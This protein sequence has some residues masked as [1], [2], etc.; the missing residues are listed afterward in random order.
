MANFDQAHHFV[1]RAEGGY[2]ADPRDRGNWTGGRI[3]YGKLVGTNWGISAPVLRAWRGRD[4]TAQE[5]QE[6]AEEEAAAIY[7]RHYWDA[8]ALDDLQ[9]APLALL[10]YD[11]AVNQGVGLIRRAVLHTLGVLRVPPKGPETPQLI[12][13]L[14]DLPAAAVHELV[15]QYRRDRYPA[16]SPFYRG[17]MKRLEKLRRPSEA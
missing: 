8:L 11:G 4:V 10:L 12:R 5:M 1:R 9:D 6:L 15:W 7:R 14:N 13:Q 2:Q 17:W 3:N 16:A